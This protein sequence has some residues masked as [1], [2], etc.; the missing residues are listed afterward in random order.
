MAHAFTV[1]VIDKG[2]H[3][4]R[5]FTKCRPALS[6]GAAAVRLFG[7][8]ITVVDSPRQPGQT[9]D[10]ASNGLLVALCLRHSLRRRCQL[11]PRNLW[12]GCRFR[13]NS[14]I[15][16]LRDHPASCRE[17]RCY[18]PAPTVRLGQYVQVFVRPVGVTSY[19]RIQCR[20]GHELRDPDPIVHVPAKDRSVPAVRTIADRPQG[21]RR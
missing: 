6:V 20:D 12:V 14:W 7:V 3:H 16:A 9:N 1:L 13:L 19:L 17:P 10:F 11:A 21:L 8:H 4:S 18:R 2:T 15:A 5:P